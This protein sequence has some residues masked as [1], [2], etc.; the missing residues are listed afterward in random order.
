MSFIPSTE[1]GLRYMMRRPIQE[2]VVDG[3]HRK[4]NK[5]DVNTEVEARLGRGILA[6]VDER[7]WFSGVAYAARVVDL[8]ILLSCGSS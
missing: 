7:W 3:R 4:Y 1:S 5:I 8:T 6:E 2:V